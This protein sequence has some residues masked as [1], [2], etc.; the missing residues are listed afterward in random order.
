ME[1]AHAGGAA[2]DASIATEDHTPP[3]ADKLREY[4]AAI[5]AGAE[6]AIT[7][8]EGQIAGFEETLAE[9]RAELDEARRALGGGER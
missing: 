9:K 1:A 4:H 8:I 2:F 6:K 7:K 5:A 3:A